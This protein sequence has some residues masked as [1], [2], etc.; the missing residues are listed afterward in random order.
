VSTRY[1]YLQ[2]RVQARYALLPDEAYWLQMAALKSLAAFVEEARLTR[3]AD[4]VAGLSGLS[5]VP[6][7]EQ[8]LR[9]VLLGTLRE[10]AG[11]FT[12]EWQP[13]VRWTSLLVDLP[14]ADQQRRRALAGPG[15]LA[16]EIT[17]D[18]EAEPAKEELQALAAGDGSV[19]SAWRQRWL[20]L[21][22]RHRGHPAHGIAE[23]QALV[24]R[25]LVTF[26]EL[27]VADAWP[28]RRQLEQ[29]LRMFFRRHPLQ[30]AAGLAYLALVALALERLRA[31][32]LGRALF[33][34]SEQSP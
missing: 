31:E 12:R 3:I 5:T 8:Q 16:L 15:G 17:N 4:W 19:V 2:A 30:P 18:G 6:E 11:W 25:H 9:R 1:G 29:T 34:E 27:P 22:P 28:A 14:R 13:A 21:W 23:L 26:T 24:E 32:L 10:T 20:A 33:P 7:I